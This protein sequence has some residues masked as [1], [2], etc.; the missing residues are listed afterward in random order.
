[1]NQEILVGLAVIMALGFLAQWVG[2]LLG[3][4]SILFLLIT[5]FIIGPVT[6]LIDPDKILG[7]TLLPLVSLSVAIILLEGGLSLRFREIRETRSVVIRLVSVGVLLTWVL[8]TGLAH[9]L[10]GLPWLTATLLGAITVVSGPTVVGPLLQTIRPKQ[11]AGSTLKWEGIVIDPLGVLLTVLVFEV[12]IL[13]GGGFSLEEVALI[14]GKTTLIGTGLGVVGA[15]I[16]TLFIAKHWIGESLESPAVLAVGLVVFVLA[17]L[18]TTEAGLFAVTALGVTLANQRSVSIKAIVEFKE[19]VRTLL[20]S[21]IFIILAA[22]LDP[23]ALRELNVPTFLFV[24]ALILFVRPFTV[25]VSTIGSSLTWRERGFIAAVMPRGIVAAAVSS[26]FA[27]EMMH[28]EIPGAE[29]IVSLTFMVII[30][31][32]AFYS[33]AAPLVARW[34]QVA[35]SNPQGFLI[36][37]AHPWAREIARELKKRNIR[38]LLIDTN[39]PNISAA[40]QSGLAA[41]HGSALA[42]DILDELNFEGL[43]RMLALTPNDEANSLASVRFA[44]VFGNRSVY[45]LAAESEGLN[46]AKKQSMRDI[47]GQYLWADWMTFPNIT[48]RFAAGANIRAT[49]LTSEFGWKEYQAHWSARSNPLFLLKPDGTV[50]VWAMKTPPTPQRDDTLL[51]LVLPEAKM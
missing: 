46:D 34:L 43:G 36:V 29:R 18:L 30:G 4:P 27:L 44:D 45:Q 51:A 10:L 9:L 17:N 13:N 20:I 42:E 50:H 1:M 14:T 21:T 48:D 3:L 23:A 32:V 19:N 7:D 22:R 38:T 39:R 6:G 2:W 11:R 37:G 49:K 47:H 40:R 41:F 16:L 35:D 15:L 24:A 33:V 26:I 31:T 25:L 5:G 12:V 28:L 8:S